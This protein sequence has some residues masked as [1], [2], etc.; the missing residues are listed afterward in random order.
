MT[1]Q[2]LSEKSKIKNCRCGGE[3]VSGIELVQKKGDFAYIYEIECTK[4]HK[5]IK[6][7]NDDKTT[8]KENTVRIWNEINKEKHEEEPKVRDNQRKRGNKYILP[9]DIYHQTLWMIRGYD[10][11]VEEAKAVLDE[12]SA[13]IDGQPKSTKISDST[14]MKAIKREENMVKIKIIDQ[15][16][17][18]IPEEY[19]NGVWNNVQDG[20]G[21]PKNADRS[22]Y[23]RYKS[24]FISEIARRTFLW[25]KN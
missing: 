11:M 8:A 9:K 24:K 21:F 16:L 19:R 5:K 23:A 22:T 15:E 20:K 7:E 3:P 18:E 2:I 14:A 25:G 10:R 4:C 17:S 13:T 6:S 1:N 12:S